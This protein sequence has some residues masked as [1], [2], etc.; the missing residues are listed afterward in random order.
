MMFGDYF[1]NWSREIRKENV[2]H[3]QSEL[4]IVRV[5]WHRI[6]MEQNT[7]FVTFSRNYLILINSFLFLNY[8]ATLVNPFEGAFA[9]EIR[10][11]IRIFKSSKA[12]GVDG[13]AAVILKSGDEC[14][15]EMISEL[16]NTCAEIGEDRND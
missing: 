16:T 14:L 7:L 5:K 11:I 15:T 1:G 12:A 8:F 3:S 10:D 6:R 4:G 9:S 13:I 2:V